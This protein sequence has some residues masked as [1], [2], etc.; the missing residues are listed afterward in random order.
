M[1]SLTFLFEAKQAHMS[2]SIRM[3]KAVHTDMLLTPVHSQLL[4]VKSGT[5][6]HSVA[7]AAGGRAG[8]GE[9]WGGE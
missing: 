1:C 7:D 4:Q 8:G 6:L 5:G 2:D 9:G 3:K